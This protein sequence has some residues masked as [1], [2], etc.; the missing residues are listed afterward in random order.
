M[1]GGAVKG[2]DLF[3][4]SSLI[5]DHKLTAKNREFTFSQFWRLEIQNLSVGWGCFPSE[6]LRESLF[7]V[8]LDSV[9]AIL[10]VSL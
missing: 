5:E 6:I 3:Q 7:H 2:G 4:R 10:G 8:S 1:V 9:L